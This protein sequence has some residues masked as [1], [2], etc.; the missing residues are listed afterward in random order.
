MIKRFVYNNLGETW[1]EVAETTIG[2]IAMIAVFVGI[3]TN[4]FRD[5]S[6]GPVAWA[7][8]FSQLFM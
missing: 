4:G 2:I 7:D 5:F 6:R 3:V 1:Q 8:I